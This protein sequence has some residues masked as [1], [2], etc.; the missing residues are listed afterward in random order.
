MTI[1]QIIRARIEMELT[2]LCDDDRL[3]VGDHLLVTAPGDASDWP[4]TERYGFEGGHEVTVRLAWL[5]TRHVEGG[6][7][8]TSTM[9]EITR[10]DHFAWARAS[11]HSW[12]ASINPSITGAA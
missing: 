9:Y 1:D 12:A 3:A 4:L 5:T 6:S 10:H 11:H 2:L 7:Y 8:T